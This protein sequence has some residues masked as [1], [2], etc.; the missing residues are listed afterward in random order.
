M[1]TSEDQTTGGGAD[2][3]QQDGAAD[4]AASL[5][6]GSPETPKKTTTRKKANS[7]ADASNTGDADNAA[8]GAGTAQGDGVGESGSSDTATPTAQADTNSGVGDAQ[9]GTDAVPEATSA[10]TDQANTN[11]SQVDGVG[12]AGSG[13]TS[14]GLDTQGGDSPVQGVAA[15]AGD[16]EVTTEQ[17]ESQ[18]ASSTDPS[19]TNQPKES[20]VIKVYNK[21]RIK[22][23]PVS[24]IRLGSLVATDI[25]FKTSAERDQILASI[26]SLNHLKNTLTIQVVE[27]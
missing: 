3:A 24:K 9:G 5:A 11:T 13:D 23:E 25:P 12:E 27:D 16:T 21:G 22:I 14:G 8:Q 4:N 2:T 17:G 1:Q 19:N 6:N 7:A 18:S 15:P 20:G 10:Q 26:K